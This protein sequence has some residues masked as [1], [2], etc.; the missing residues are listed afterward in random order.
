[1]KKYIPLVFFIA[2]VLAAAYLNTYL[3]RQRMP[4]KLPPID[5]YFSPKGGCTDAIVQEIDA[6]QKTILVQAYSFTS[7][8][9]AK[10]LVAAHKRGVKTSVILDSEQETTNY[11]E[12]DFL[13]H[14]GM[15]PLIDARHAIAHNKIMILDEGVVITGSFNFTK[16]AETNNAENLLV[17][18]DQFIAKVYA[19][20]W[21]AHAAHSRPYEAKRQTDRDGQPER[22]PSKT[23]QGSSRN[24]QNGLEKA[25]K[26]LMN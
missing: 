11:S 20:N 6:A 7:K 9:I 3:R 8:P 10:A 18:R 14:E 16:N 17:I 21:N 19:D 15:T 5:V 22:R 24:G 1:M 23:R 4:D 25:M 13:V 12:A 2:F 26:S